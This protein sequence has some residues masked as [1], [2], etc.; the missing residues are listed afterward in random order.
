MSERVWTNE[1]IVSAFDRLTKGVV[2]KTVKPAHGLAELIV[3]MRTDHEQ[4]IAEVE[5]TNR[6]L[7]AEVRR[8][9]AETASQMHEQAEWMTKA[10]D[11]EAAL[12]RARTYT[13]VEAQ[14][15][16]LCRY[17]NGV[18]VEPCAMHKEI[19]ELR[20]AVV[21]AEKERDVA[22]IGAC[23]TTVLLNRIQ[24]LKAQLAAAK[25]AGGTMAAQLVPIVAQ[26]RGCGYECEAGPLERNTSF[27]E[28]TQLARQKMS[29]CHEEES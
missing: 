7:E 27:I 26:L 3:T 22:L 18:F 8:L 17:E 13:G 9:E 2:T 10:V 6:T 15:C 25:A 12:E 14:A 23:L 28:L 4:R 5:Q 21:L 16:P 11:L 20:A 24:D 29:E 1:E 19:D